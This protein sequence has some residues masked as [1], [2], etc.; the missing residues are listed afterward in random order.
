MKATVFQREEVELAKPYLSLAVLQGI[1]P[2]PVGKYKL[3]MSRRWLPMHTP[4]G[5]NLR[6]ST[7][8]YTVMLIIP[9]K[10][11]RLAECTDSLQCTDEVK[12][13][14]RRTHPCGC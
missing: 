5:A 10:R 12:D 3:S 11:N 13:V 2:F 9:K 14:S 4:G 1:G 6:H 7:T 8:R